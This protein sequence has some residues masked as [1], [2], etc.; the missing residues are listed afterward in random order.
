MVDR[1]AVLKIAKQFTGKETAMI[2]SEVDENGTCE[3]LIAGCGIAMLHS[4][5]GIINR[6]AYHSGTNFEEVIAAIET[7]REMEK[8]SYSFKSN[9]DTTDFDSIDFDDEE[10]YFEI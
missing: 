1:D 4:L 7:M 6:I 9:R 2:H 3:L 5:V 10:G 8:D